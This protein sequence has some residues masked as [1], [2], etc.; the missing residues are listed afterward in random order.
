[1]TSKGTTKFLAG[2][3]AIGGIFAF[4]GVWYLVRT[5]PVDFE[6]QANGKIFHLSVTD[7]SDGNNP[8]LQYERNFSNNTLSGTQVRIT[9]DD[10]GNY[11][12]W[13]IVDLGISQYN[14]TLDLTHQYVLNDQQYGAEITIVVDG[15]GSYD[16]CN[17][18][19]KLLVT[20]IV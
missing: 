3:I 18:G 5:Q 19:G 14:V 10:P 7:F 12:L 1:M 11:M 16:E 9:V 4:I 2:L 8:L 17:F 20:N 15:D 13:I 6:F